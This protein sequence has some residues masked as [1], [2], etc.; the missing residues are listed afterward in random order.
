M[1]LAGVDLN[2]LVTLDALLRERNVTRAARRVGL[3][4]PAMSNALGRLRRLFEDPLFVRTPDGMQPTPRA[5]ALAAP[6]AD[7]LHRL[8]NAVLTPT[9]F[10]PQTLS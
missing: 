9:N 7:A 8:E 2:L 10:V 3:S 1:Q 5:A 4:Q 6:L